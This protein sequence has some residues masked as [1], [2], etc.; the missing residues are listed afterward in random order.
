M[1]W[2]DVKVQLIDTPPI[3]ADSWKAT[4]RA[5]CAPPTPPILML[6]LGD[7]DGPFAAETVLERLAQV[8]TVLIGQMPA[9]QEDLTDP[10]RQDAARRQQDRLAGGRSAGDRPRNVRSI[11]DPA[12][13]TSRGTATTT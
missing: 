7:D 8:K 11:S 1:D 13:S 12:R 6:D 10:V 2:Q 4:S 3:T 5:W 9:E